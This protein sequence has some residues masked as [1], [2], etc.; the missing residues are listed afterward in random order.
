MKT[1]TKGE[2]SEEEIKQLRTIIFE[3]KKLTE[4]LKH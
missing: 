3:M 1:S 2:D 4:E